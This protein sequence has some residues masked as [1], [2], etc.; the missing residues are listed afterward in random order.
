VLLVAEAD[1]VEV[2]LALTGDVAENPAAGVSLAKLPCTEA[3]ATS[4]KPE[5]VA[6]S[7]VLADSEPRAEES[8][9]EE[10]SLLLLRVERT[11]PAI[12]ASRTGMASMTQREDV[13]RREWVRGGGEGSLSVL[14]ESVSVSVLSRELSLSESVSLGCVEEARG[15]QD[16]RPDEEMKERRRTKERRKQEL[17]PHGPCFAVRPTARTPAATL[18]IR[19]K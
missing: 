5:L 11:S 12:A 14:S 2:P 16:E 10:E 8:T 19:S 6:L 17:P 7:E 1:A 3:V 4:A 13:R 9:T 15:M 18:N